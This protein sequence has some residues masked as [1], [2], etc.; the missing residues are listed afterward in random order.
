M[1]LAVAGA[2]IPVLVAGSAL[3]AAHSEKAVDTA[4]VSYP[5]ASVSYPAVAGPEAGGWGRGGY[6]MMPGPAGSASSS[7]APGSSAQGAVANAANAGATSQN[8]AG[9]TSAGAAGT[10]TSVSAS[11]AEPA[12]TCTATNTFSSFWVG[13]DG[14]GTNSVEQTGT[15]AD[16]NAGAPS[17]QGWFEMFP[18]APVFFSNPVQP[19]DAMSASVVANGGG[20]F[21]LTLTDT[22]QGWTQQTSQSSNIAQ[23][24]SAEVIAEAPSSGNGTVLPLSNFGTVNFT[25]ATVDNTALG[26]ENASALTMVSGNNVTEATPSALTGGTAFTVTWDSDG[27]TATPAH[28]PAATATPATTVPVGTT[29]AATTAPAGTAPPRPPAPPRPDITGDVRPETPEIQEFL[30]ARGAGRLAHPGGNLYGHLNRVAAL[31]ADWGADE[32]LQVTGLCHACYG[33]DGY[34]QALLTLDERP[35]LRALVGAW[36][37]SLVYLYGSCDRT[38]VYPL[39]AGPGPVRFRDRFTG[40]IH[41]PPE[42]D[43][44]AFT[45]LTAANELD[46]MR[47][48]D[49]MAARYGAPLRRLVA[50]AAPRLTDAARQAWSRL[51]GPGPDTGHADPGSEGGSITWV[52][53]HRPRR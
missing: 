3:M 53:P 41:T 42:P 40:D 18:A 38:A 4:S 17:Y 10:F 25:G 34:D 29:P 22:T 47:H 24:G 32:D 28:T 44:R 26:N 48:S 8:W 37:E 31:L 39:L 12:V 13:L 19:G 35:V 6:M 9:Y 15:E 16:C 11:W 2:G 23:L 1:A 50:A 14:D 7:S 52:R 27:T 36:V 45:E 46:V 51:P 49:A 43:V 21:T 33:T 5:A 30:L 20:A